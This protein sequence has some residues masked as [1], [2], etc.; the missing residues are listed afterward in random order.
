MYSSLSL[1]EGNPIGTIV[2]G[3]MNRKIV[4][5]KPSDKKINTEFTIKDDGVIVPF[6]IKQLDGE[7][8][9]RIVI[10]G[11]SLCGKSYF[12]KELAQNYSEDFPDNR[13]ALF[14]GIPRIK[15]NIFA[16]D[17]CRN[18][19]EDDKKAKKKI[20]K[21]FCSK[22]MRIKCD[23]SILDDPIDLGELSNT[24]AIFDDVDRVPNKEVAKEL[25]LLRDKVMNSGR[26]DNTDLMSIS[27]ILL[28]GKKTKTSL[29]NAF[30]LVCFPV[31]GGRYQIKEYLKRYMSLDSHIVDKVINLPSRWV[32]LNNCKPLYVLYEKGCF[33]V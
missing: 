12:A 31:S 22:I 13:I 16:C 17:Q 19:D 18:K 26:H 11:P 2:G 33:I 29:T 20:Y 25:N 1:I 21:C 27:Q 23:E 32:I 3:S 10:S 8:P 14:T 4:K 5:I 9:N 7:F 30:Q 6:Y 15:D 24:L 28:E